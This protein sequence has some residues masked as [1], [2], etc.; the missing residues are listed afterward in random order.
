MSEN[1]VMID[2]KYVA[3]S[4]GNKLRRWLFEQGGT[5]SFDSELLEEVVHFVEYPIALCGRFEKSIWIFRQKQLLRLCGNINA[6]FRFLDLMENCYRCLLPCAMA[7]WTYIDLVVTAT[8]VV[9]KARLADARFFFEEDKKVPW[10]ERLDKLKT[11][12]YQ[13]G[14]GTLYDK[15]LRL[16]RLADYIAT[17]GGSLQGFPV[18]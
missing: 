16:E 17:E 4:S 15:T 13:E 3:A 10:R 2:Q 9:L 5:A 7:E 14:L 12:V 8:N 11:I 1:L 18:D 6:I